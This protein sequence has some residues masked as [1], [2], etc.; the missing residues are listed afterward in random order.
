MNIPK[1]KKPQG[2]FATMFCQTNDYQ[3]LGFDKQISE[4][5]LLPTK[6]PVKF[7]K[8]LKSKFDLP[9]FIPV[10]FYQSYYKSQTNGRDYPLESMLSVLL[11]VH[12][13]HYWSIPNFNVLLCFSSE[14]RDFC[15]LPEGSIPD[16]S[17]YSKFKTNFDVELNR[18]F[19]SIASNV[20]NIFT[21]Y[22]ES[23]PEDSPL[24]GLSEEV[25]IDTTGLKPKVKE[26]NPKTIATEI[27]RQSNYKNWLKSK[28]DAK[29]D[30]FNVYAAAYA[31][32]PKT[33]AA[34]PVLKLD[35]ANSDRKLK[36]SSGCFKGGTFKSPLEI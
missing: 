31:G 19:D 26:Y 10:S 6:N 22:N 33:A 17:V 8:L 4:I 9:T 15:R 3:Q 27:K 24:K 32:M 2:G 25:I 36:T 30:N 34:N 23:L 28:G 29:A 5:T 14:I 18:F 13:F 20:M 7:L 1:I 11:L 12:F 16:E 21:E 35:Y